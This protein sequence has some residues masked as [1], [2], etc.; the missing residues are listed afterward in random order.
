MKDDNFVSN[1]EKDIL[2]AFLVFDTDHNGFISAENL[3]HIMMNIGESLT[4]K[5]SEEFINLVDDD[6]DGHINYQKL[7]KILSN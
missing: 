5:E 3:K 2:D 7:V 1:N 6:G 4:S